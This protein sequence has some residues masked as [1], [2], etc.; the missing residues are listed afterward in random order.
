M[1]RLV[2]ITSGRSRRNAFAAL[3][4]IASA[5]TS[6]AASKIEREHRKACIGQLRRRR[7]PVRVRPPEHV[8]K[9]DARCR[10]PRWLVVRAGQRHAVSGANRDA[11]PVTPAE[12]AKL[13][14]RRRRGRLQDGDAQ[15]SDRG[16]PRQDSPQYERRVRRPGPAF[17]PARPASAKRIQIVPHR[18]LKA[19]KQR[20][21]DERVADRDFREMRQPCG[22]AAGSAD[23]DRVRHSRQGR[24]SAPVPP[25]RRR[26]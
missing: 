25:P 19:D 23:R 22:T 1:P 11:P 2:G 7:V 16:G 10:A 17:G 6:V 26:S 13:S 3:T 8:K 21:A 18:S 15:E 20:V 9:D 24:A 12:D 5:P 4:S 14:R